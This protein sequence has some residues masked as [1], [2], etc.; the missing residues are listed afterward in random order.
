MSLNINSVNS[1]GTSKL[2]PMIIDTTQQKQDIIPLPGQLPVKLHPLWT[3][4]YFST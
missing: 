1:T 2:E 3:K 4:N